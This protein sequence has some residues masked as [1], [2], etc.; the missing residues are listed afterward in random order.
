MNIMTC[1][2]YVLKISSIVN[3]RQIRVIYGCM[4]VMNDAG[5]F[6]WVVRIKRRWE[7]KR[8]LNGGID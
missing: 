3:H 2:Q 7:E 8:A 1:I 6:M 5:S 4:F